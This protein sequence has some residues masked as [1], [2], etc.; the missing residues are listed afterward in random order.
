MNRP[1]NTVCVSAV[2]HEDALCQFPTKGG[3]RRNSPIHAQRPLHVALR[4]WD[5]GKEQELGLS[6]NTKARQIPEIGTGGR[7]CS[8]FH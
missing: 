7:I 4:N 5:I 2:A 8:L 3:T 6:Y 1:L